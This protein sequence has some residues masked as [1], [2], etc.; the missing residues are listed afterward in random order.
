LW[1]IHN[2]G[3]L[4]AAPGAALTGVNARDGRHGSSIMSW[5]ALVDT[6]GGRAS[7]QIRDRVT[8]L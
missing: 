7:Q 5:T 6:S 1:T 4:P 3:L 2:A 8:E